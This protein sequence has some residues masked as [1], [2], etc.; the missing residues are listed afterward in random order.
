MCV[1]EQQEGCYI[2][3]TTAKYEKLPAYCLAS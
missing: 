3:Q 1:K 2:A